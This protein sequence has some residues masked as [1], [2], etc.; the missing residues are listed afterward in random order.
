MLI[1]EKQ[2]Q[3]RL[4]SESNLLNKVERNNSHFE[5]RATNHG[6]RTE[7][8]KNLTDEERAE[9]GTLALTTP[10]QVVAE[11]YGISRQHV[12]N[13]KFGRVDSRRHVDK[14]HPKLRAALSDARHEIKDKALLRLMQSLNLIEPD[15]VAELDAKDI[16]AVAVN[17]SKVVSNMEPKESR[18]NGTKIVIYA[19]QVK[20]V[21]EFEV[22]DV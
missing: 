12:E 15:N 2:A 16:S 3:A 9:I 4:E 14:E 18:D 19:P 6:G 21:E 7:G 10:A 13:L 1:T 17:M 8:K 11:G 20:K 22:I 5:L